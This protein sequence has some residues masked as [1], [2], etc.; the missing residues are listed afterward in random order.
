MTNFFFRGWTIKC[1]RT[2]SDLLCV[3][4]YGSLHLRGR[5]ERA[6]QY[7]LPP[8]ISL[9]KPTDGGCWGCYRRQ[10]KGGKK[11]GGTRKERERE[12]KVSPVLDHYLSCAWRLDHPPPPPTQYIG[13]R[14]GG[15]VHPRGGR[16]KNGSLARGNVD[17][18]ALGA[19]TTFKPDFNES[20]KV[21]WKLC[22]TSASGVKQ[23]P[24]WAST[25]MA[26]FSPPLFRPPP[27]KKKEGR[28]EFVIFAQRRR[29]RQIDKFSLFFH[30]LFSLPA[31]KKLFFSTAPIRIKR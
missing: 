19:T 25:F 17:N 6:W 10:R 30:L 13:R 18:V 16:S 9:M 24:S 14:K 26:V 4:A 8:L 11:G 27:P 12:K 7:L 20:L 28:K 5:S 1:R 31:M 15:R 3:F 22:P 2:F 21:Q 23:S 29:N